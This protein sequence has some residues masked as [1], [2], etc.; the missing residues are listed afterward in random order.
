MIIGTSKNLSLICTLWDKK[1]LAQWEGA[2]QVENLWQT[3]NGQGQIL[4]M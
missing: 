1:I 3:A 4:E 2:L